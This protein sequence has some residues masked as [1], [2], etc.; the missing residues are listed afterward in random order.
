VAQ[1]EAHPDL[2]S[3]MRRRYRLHSDAFM[4]QIADDAAIR[5]IEHNVDESTQLVPVLR[6]GLLRGRCS[7]I[8]TCTTGNQVGQG[9]I[10]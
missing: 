6:P 2:L 8:H 3:R 1:L 4:A 7:Y 5:L 10:R 9:P